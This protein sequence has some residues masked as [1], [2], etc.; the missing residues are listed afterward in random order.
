[1][2][3][4]EVLATGVAAAEIAVLAVA[5]TAAADHR[6]QLAEAAGNLVAAASDCSQGNL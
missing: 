2:V 6:I 3:E 4:L 5:G 1:M